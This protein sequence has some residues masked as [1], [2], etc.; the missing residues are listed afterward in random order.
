VRKKIASVLLIAEAPGGIEPEPREESK[1]VYAYS[2]HGTKAKRITFSR[3]GDRREKVS[4]AALALCMPQSIC[5]L[6][7]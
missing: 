1:E 7:A 5:S 3:N 4:S 2:R 6:Q